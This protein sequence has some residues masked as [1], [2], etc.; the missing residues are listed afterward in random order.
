MSGTSAEHGSAAETRGP[1]RKPWYTRIA[2][3][4]VTLTKELLDEIVRI[5]VREAQPEKIILFG[6]HAR[7]NANPTSDVDLLVVETEVSDARAEIVRLLRALSPLKL[8]VDLLVTESSRLESSWA[9]YPGSYL[10]HALRE[11]KVL[12]A[13]DRRSPVAVA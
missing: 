11:G 6:S 5:L 9:Y 10:Y 4:P 3:E 8:S 12:Y 13:L 2:M 1:K 7:G